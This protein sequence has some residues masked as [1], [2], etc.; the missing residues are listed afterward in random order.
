M[1]SLFADNPY[2]LKMNILKILLKKTNK[3][4][5]MYIHPVTYRSNPKHLQKSD[6]VKRFDY[7]N[8]PAQQRL[9]GGL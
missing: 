6:N 9:K 2:L 8:K 5:V 4:D 7:Q 3:G 1:Y